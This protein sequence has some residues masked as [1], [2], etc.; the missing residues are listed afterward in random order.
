MCAELIA[1]GGVAQKLL[2]ANEY[3][4]R[5]MDYVDNETA[6]ATQAAVD[7]MYELIEKNGDE[8]YRVE[9]LPR[10]S[11]VDTALYDYGG[12]TVF[13]SSGSYETTQLMSHLGYASN[14]I[15]SY[16][17]KGYTAPT[18]SLFGVKY[19]ALTNHIVGH[20]QLVEVDQVLV[21]ETSYYIYEN[22]YALPLAYPVGDNMLNWNAY[23]YNPIDTINTLYTEMVGVDNV[24]TVY[25]LDPSL[26]GDTT[27]VTRGTTAFSINDNGSK[28]TTAT[29]KVTVP[30]NG[31]AIVYVDCRA[32]ENISVSAGSNSWGVTPYEP[33][34][35][36]AGSLAAGDVVTVTLRVEQSCSGNIY[37]ASL[38]ETVLDEAYAKLTAGAMQVTEHSDRYVAGKITADKRQLMMTGIP[39]D[40][41][42]TVKV[43]GKKVNTEIVADG[44][45]MGF[46]VEAGEH[47]VEISF[48]PKGLGLG[49]AVSV[50][51]I[52]LTVLLALA[53]SQKR[54]AK[55]AKPAPAEPVSTLDIDE[56]D[57]T[58]ETV[59]PDTATSPNDEKDVT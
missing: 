30:A 14:G 20:Q 50:A 9:F 34:I 47:D 39:Y 26:E 54:C 19:V 3:Y 2:N 59:I 25:P 42:W 11:C 18:D 45:M 29:F 4:T 38:N 5:H 35:I 37:V 43:D 56:Q 51:S 12:L 48:M 33:Y 22:P 15:N 57:V 8:F 58:V 21:G 46:Y 32:A 40:Q 53:T 10:R 28:N 17:Y 16:L 13:A 1:H 52:A 27:A 49:I 44:A 7:K 41:G 24:Y 31:Q 23:D 55:R 36:D 6:A